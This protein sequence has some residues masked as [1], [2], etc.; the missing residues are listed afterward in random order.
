M[1]R[2][3]FLLVFIAFIGVY[4]LMPINSFAIEN[5]ISDSTVVLTD[6]NNINSWMNDY[7]TDEGSC[8]SILGDPSNPKSVAWLVVTVLNYFRIIGPLA[9]IVLSGVDY[10]KAIINSDDDALKKTH[11]R[12]VKRLILA[13]LL[14]LIPTVVDLLLKVFNIVSDPLCGIGN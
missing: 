8:S 7:N 4:F 9:V 13:A 1:K 6:S 3:L 5:T 11:S 2:N 12:L 14:F 10:V